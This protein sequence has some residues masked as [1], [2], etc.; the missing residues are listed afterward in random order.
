MPSQED[1]LDSLL[2]N[3]EKDPMGESGTEQPDGLVD[4]PAGDDAL[5]EN[6][7]SDLESAI[8]SDGNLNLELLGLDSEQDGFDESDP[9]SSDEGTLSDDDLLSMLDGV[10]DDDLRDIHKML[11]RADKNEAVDVPVLRQGSSDE[12]GA[13]EPEEQKPLSKR[14]QRAQ[15]RKIRKQE[16]A[17]AKAAAKA[18]KLAAKEAAKAAKKGRAVAG[19]PAG[20]SPV[21][22]AGAV[23]GRP[24]SSNPLFD[25]SLLD[26][27][28]ADAS[29]A[30]NEERSLRGGMGV[31]TGQ[32]KS[33]PDTLDLDMDSLFEDEGKS[34]LSG[35]APDFPDFLA[36]DAEEADS[37]IPEHEK[38]EQ[39]KK[40]FFSK[41][42]DFLTEADEDEESE[43]LQLSDENR[44]IL[45]DL[46]KEKAGDKKKKKKKG[47]GG[48]GKEKG[49]KAKKPKK[50]KKEKPKKEKIPEPE[51]LIPE[52]KLTLKSVLPVVLACV[53]FGVFIIVFVNA[54][55]DFTYKQ[56]AREAYYA[57][58]YETCFQNLY[59][60]D[61]N[62][63]EQAMFRKSE[64]ILYIRLWLREYE[65]LA[66][67][68]A[69]VEAL[70]S[71]L[72]TVKDYPKLYGYAVQW[73]AGA[74]VSAGYQTIL[75]ILLEKYGLTEEQ[76]KEIA[77]VR[78]D[79]EYTR[80]VVGVVYGYAYGSGNELA[81]T[82][83]P[84]P[85]QAPLQDVLPEEEGLID[86]GFINN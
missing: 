26:S 64:S 86:G 82:P 55:V 61:L 44:E 67:E 15:Q 85:E 76:A 31:P 23:K 77:A 3:L 43:S 30:G 32:D 13:S 51:P 18:E 14:E 73:D 72:Q 7:W 74:E 39:V 6:A 46:D 12:G 34:D 84:E 11:D 35:D 58:D 81:S 80:M 38:P 36:V 4:E 54:S 19:N 17:E 28:V 16:K 78:N 53:S 42:F 2:K 60:K 66:D 21:A 56:T 79:R 69:E 27:I 47:D 63:T 10:D 20:D 52:R 68:N 50:P 48:K 1:Y 75:N 62:E 22:N 71:L 37:L 59:G 8:D 65:I 83:E 70:D 49:D 24:V 33:D 9:M 57:G 41:I 25:A 5:L 40:S 45:N 29:Q